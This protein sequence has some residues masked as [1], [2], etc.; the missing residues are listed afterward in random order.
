[1]RV[2]VWSGTTTSSTDRLYDVPIE[3]HVRTLIVR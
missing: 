1:M 2:L 3:E